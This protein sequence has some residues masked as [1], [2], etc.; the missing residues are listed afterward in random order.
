V[1]QSY[2]SAI[3]SPVIADRRSSRVLGLTREH[4]SSMEPAPRRAVI[5]AGLSGL[6]DG[7]MPP[8]SNRAKR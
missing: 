6:R 8:G 4:A 3:R 5:V 7:E 2:H 1:S